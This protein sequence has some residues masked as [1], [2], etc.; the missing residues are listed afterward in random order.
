MA[1][2][3]EEA[4]AE[5][6]WLVRF[7]CNRLERRITREIRNQ[8]T[9]GQTVFFKLRFYHIDEYVLAEVER[10]F[11][12]WEIEYRPLRYGPPVMKVVEKTRIP[13]DRPLV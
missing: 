8:W 5:K 6:R 11:P 4:L 10:R 9:P 3:V 7:R 2:T 13:V 1:V 12:E